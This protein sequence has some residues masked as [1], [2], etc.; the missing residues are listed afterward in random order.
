MRYEVL[1]PLRV[2]GAAPGTALN[3]YK[4]RVLLG[5]LLTRA[6]HVVAMDRLITD[7]WDGG[8]PRTAVGAVH[9]HICRLRRQL[10]DGAIT[11]TPRGYRINVDEFDLTLFRDAAKRGR[12]HA[13]A[14]RHAQAVDDLGTAL[15]LWRGPALDGLTDNIALGGF[16]ASLDDDRLACAEAYADS[17]LILGRHREMAGTLRQLV[18][19]HPLHE[20]L[21]H[22]LM[23]ALHLSGQ[24]TEALMA[25][26]SASAI[27]RREIG[28]EPGREL[29]SLYRE[30]RHELVPAA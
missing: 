1:G 19:E 15:A 20:P 21:H 17:G 22:R 14:G 23:I 7:I 10:G 18:V 8:P 3:A 4:V 26:A 6:G 13:A 9:V 29:Q 27:L 28:L 11:T 16:S 2:L 12:D 25:Y 24:K 5:V 30:I